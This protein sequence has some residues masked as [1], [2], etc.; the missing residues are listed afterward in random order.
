ML[1]YPVGTLNPKTSDALFRMSIN[2][3]LGIGTTFAL[4]LPSGQTYDFWWTP[5]DGSSA[6]HVTAYNDA[7]ATYDYGT[8]FI[9]QISIEGKC[10]GFSFN[11]GGDRLKVISVDQWGNVGFE[12]IDFY[13]CTN[14]S[15]LPLDE[16]LE[17]TPL[18]T[19]ITQ[20]VRNCISLT[21][22]PVKTFSNS[23]LIVNTFRAFYTAGLTSLNADMFRYCTAITSFRECFAGYKGVSIPPD[24]FRY[25]VNV[26]TF[27][28]CFV[29]S[30][31]LRNIPENVFFYNK[32]VTDY[33]GVFQST[34]LLNLPLVMFDLSVLNIVTDFTN[35]MNI[36]SPVNS[37]NGIIQDIWNYALSA[38][39]L[40]ALVN[41]TALTNYA[42]IPNAWKGL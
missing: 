23:T 38:T 13:G 40:N 8:P 32:L 22:I 17:K 34:K 16:A 2:T 37:S 31:T 21:D 24:F 42:S 25:N 3:A 7:T 39:S 18:I 6:R 29:S 27:N 14:L 19:G 36:T 4:P 9:G 33:R 12:I 28:Q 11:N 26:T 35:F 5:G 20:F 30:T 10:G 1:T 41:Q 15:S